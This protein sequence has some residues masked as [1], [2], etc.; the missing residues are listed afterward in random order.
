MECRTLLQPAEGGGGVVVP[1][2]EG[3]MRTQELVAFCSLIHVYSLCEHPS[4]W[5]L[6]ICVL[7]SRPVVLSLFDH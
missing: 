5:T 7:L 1:L 2:G 4:S 6:L 3:A